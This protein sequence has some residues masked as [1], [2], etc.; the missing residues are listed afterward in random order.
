MDA[1]TRVGVLSEEDSKVFAISEREFYRNYAML[2]AYLYEGQ[3]SKAQRQ[4]YISAFSR[5]FP[6]DPAVKFIVDNLAVHDD[7]PSL[8]GLLDAGVLKASYKSMLEESETAYI[9]NEADAY[10]L[11]TLAGKQAQ[12]LTLRREMA[13]TLDKIDEESEETLTGKLSQWTSLLQTQQ[14]AV[15]DYSPDAVLDRRK[16]RRDSGCYFFVGPLDDVV[17]SLSPGSTAIIG[18]FAGSGK[19]QFTLNMLYQNAVSVKKNCVILTLEMSKDEYILYLL[20]RHSRND[21]WRDFPQA[22]IDKRLLLSGQFSEEQ[23][24]FLKTT[25]A[26]DLFENPERGEIHIL[27]GEDFPVMTPEAIQQK[28]FQACPRVD[29]FFLDYT[30]VFKAYPAPIRGLEDPKERINYF[31]KKLDLM[32]RNFYGRDINVVLVSQINREG[33]KQYLRDLSTDLKKGANSRG[34]DA[35][36][37]KDANE[38]EASAWYLVSLFSNDDMMERGIIDCQLLKHRGGP[39]IE[40]PFGLHVEPQY[41][42]VGNEGDENYRQ[43]V[44]LGELDLEAATNDPELELWFQERQEKGDE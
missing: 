9:P 3:L 4:Q 30:N 14:Q 24:A 33:Y 1:T 23:E 2:F 26:P 16:E 25:L 40:T 22:R 41:A 17:G 6:D 31:I 43:R 7:I 10:R 21:M 19:T 27:S 8:A 15:V 11:L 36:A 39:K 5:V 12:A 34:Y 44:N 37:F 13:E 28:V 20:A 42:Y 18:G 38:N 32:A 35:T 29:M